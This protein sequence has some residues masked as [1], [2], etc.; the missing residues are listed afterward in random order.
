[1]CEMGHGDDVEMLEVVIPAGFA[2]REV[3]SFEA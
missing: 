3:E 1:V 2:T